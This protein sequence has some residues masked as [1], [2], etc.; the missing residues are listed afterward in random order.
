MIKKPRILVISGYGFNCEEETKFAFQITGGLSDIIHINDLINN[1]KL[2]KQYQILALPGGFS[3]GDDTGSGNA[4]ALKIKNHLWDTLMQFVSGDH[5]VIGICNG[6]QV[7]VNLGLVPALNKQYGK[8]EV[9]LL[10]NT[11]VRY[12]VRWTDVKVVSDCP[13]FIGINRIS[14]PI[15]HG[16]GR[17]Y[18]S[19]KTLNLLED[20]KMIALKYVPG[21]ISKKT[22]LAYN[23]TGTLRDIAAITDGSKR[24]LG[25]MPHPER[26]VFFNQLP[27][28]TLLKELYFR[29]R[30]K[31]PI[32]GPGLKIFQNAIT[33]FR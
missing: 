24:I 1:K 23:P 7:L 2:F 20:K 21:E 18:A 25:M 28:W 26:A 4:M 5:L 8:R 22:D 15:A 33:Y 11:N 10:S 19:E 9:A 29:Q 12:T 31:L 30:K 3:Y 14:L 6:F 13:W 17:F 16:E 32:Y 27:N